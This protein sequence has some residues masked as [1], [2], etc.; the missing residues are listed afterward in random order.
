[1]SPRVMV[2]TISRELRLI[3]DLGL[4]V[5]FVADGVGSGPILTVRPLDCWTLPVLGAVSLNMS[6]RVMVYTISRE[7]RLIVDLGVFVFFVADG[8][9][10]GPKLT[11]RPFEFWTPPV[12]GGIITDSE[13]DAEDGDFFEPFS[14]SLRSS[15]PSSSLPSFDPTSTV[16]LL[17]MASLIAKTSKLPRFILDLV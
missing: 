17:S 1:M 6:P 15:S 7:L 8:V 10:S 3:A 5:L 2:Y 4:L 9:G 12:A 13:M 14:K 11:D 16:E